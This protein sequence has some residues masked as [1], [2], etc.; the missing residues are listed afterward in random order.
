LFIKQRIIHGGALLKYDPPGVKTFKRKR[1]H[2]FLTVKGTLYFGDVEQVRRYVFAVIKFINHYNLWTGK[3]IM[4]ISREA[5]AMIMLYHWP[6]NVRELENAIEH[7]FVICQDQLIRI[8]HLPERIIPVRG[9]LAITDGLTAQRS[10]KTGDHG[11][12]AKE[13]EQN[14]GHR[15]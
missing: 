8:Q 2:R 3:N 10:R 12:S 4:G 15:P 6:G 7:A 1:R 13:P 14:N 9:S 11:G 5:M